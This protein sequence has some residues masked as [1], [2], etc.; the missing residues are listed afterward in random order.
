MGVNFELTML[1]RIL[2]DRS[3]NV[4]YL[5]KLVS[6]GLKTLKQY[7]PYRFPDKLEYKYFDM[8]G[9]ID[10]TELNDVL[11]RLNNSNKVMNN[12]ISSLKRNIKSFNIGMVRNIPTIMGHVDVFRDSIDKPK[13]G[14]VL[15]RVNYEVVESIMELYKRPTYQDSIYE[16]IVILINELEVIQNTI[17]RP[18]TDE[19]IVKN[20]KAIIY[21]LT[22]Y[23]YNLLKHYQIDEYI[24]IDCLKR[25][26]PNYVFGYTSEYIFDSIN[27]GGSRCQIKRQ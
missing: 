5:K 20:N 24:T 18:D 25:I 1:E 19:E 16:I 26:I 14:E 21:Q 27:R 23:T 13:S 6:M 10:L 12:H 4:D 7:R 22:G 3:D 15:H 2:S 17:R 8:H 9:Y 11:N